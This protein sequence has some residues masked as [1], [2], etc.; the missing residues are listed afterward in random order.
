MHTRELQIGS[1]T[2]SIETGR[3]AKQADG[4]VLVRLRRFGRAR[5]GVLR[6]DGAGRHRLSAVDGRLPRIHLRLGPHPRRLL[7][8]RGEA[9]RKGSADQPRDR[10]ADPAALPLG[11]APRDADHRARALGRHA[12]RHRRPRDHRRLGGAGA[13]GDPVPHDDRRCAR[14]PGRRPVRHQPDLRAAEAQQARYHRRRQQGR[15]GDG[16]GRRQGS[17]RGRSRPG[18]RGRARRDQEDRRHDQRPG[19]GRRQAEADRHEEG[20]RRPSSIARSKRRFTFR[21]ARRC[22][23]AGS[24]R[25]TTASISCRT[26]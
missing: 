5:H 22:G 17:E 12:E 20:N 25:T 6:R 9:G 18:A 15:P 4:A 14:R 13:V 8:A 16:R 3:L 19:E 1:Q 26:S 7:Q 23:S 24:S 2:L 11:M 10:S 21:S